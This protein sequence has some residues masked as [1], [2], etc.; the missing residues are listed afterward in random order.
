MI[1]TLVKSAE[2]AAQDLLA[3]S[4]CTKFYKECIGRKVNALKQNPTI[5]GV[6]NVLSDLALIAEKMQGGECDASAE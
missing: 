4:A 2:Q 1:N 3:S 6:A 5:V